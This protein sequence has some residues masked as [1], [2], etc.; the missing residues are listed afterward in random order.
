MSK[1]KYLFCM[2]ATALYEG[3]TPSR[4]SREG[5]HDVNMLTPCMGKQR[6]KKWTFI[7]VKN[8]RKELNVPTFQGGIRSL[9]QNN[10]GM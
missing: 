4:S 3:A 5:V 10:M 9:P 2:I 6:L 7:S 8:P 1:L